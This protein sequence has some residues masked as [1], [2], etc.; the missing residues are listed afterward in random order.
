M[1][2]RV[3]GL[4]SLK[5]AVDFDGIFRSIKIRNSAEVCCSRRATAA[6]SCV[7]SIGIFANN[8]MVATLFSV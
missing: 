1:I 3:F 2:K 7:L 6:S 5:S 8:G 4:L